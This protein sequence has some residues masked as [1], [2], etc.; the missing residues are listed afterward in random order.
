MEI[1]IL[2]EQDASAWWNLRL[3]ALEGEPFAFGKAVEEHQ[4]TT[5]E[6]IG[7]RFREASPDNFT[8]GAFAADELI[9]M[10]TFVREMG[11]KERHKGHIYGVY[12][13]PSQRGRGV[14]R[15]MMAALLSRAREDA[16]LE[17]ILLAVATCQ[18]AASQ[19]YRQL[20]FETYGTEPN[21]LKVG[22]E[23]VDEDHMVL[24]LR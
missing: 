17:Q 18:K 9:G 19:L 10:A 20:G 21:A 15:A 3:E 14:G 22:A 2:G 13:T 23:Y 6:A 24:R 4:A 8:V 12:V 5:V 7:R 1:R 16:S 11:G